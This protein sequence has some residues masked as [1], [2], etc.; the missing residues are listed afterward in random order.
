MNATTQTGMTDSLRY[1]RLWQ[2]LSMMTSSKLSLASMKT[3]TNFYRESWRKFH[4]IEHPCEML[5]VFAKV[6]TSHLSQ[7]FIR[8]IKLMIIYHDVIYRLRGIR[9]AEEKGF[10]ERMSAELMQT[11]LREAECEEELISLVSCGILATISHS[12]KDVPEEWH[13]VVGLFLDID[14]F[15]GLGET[16]ERF[17]ENTQKIAEEFSPLFLPE[18]FFPGRKKFAEGFADR[19][20]IFHTAHFASYEPIVKSN[21]RRY[22]AEH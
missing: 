13:E 11:Q 21:L 14:L 7:L 10:S 18:E 12:L 3:T 22:V 1:S 8:A 16:Y 17:L 5:D 9:Q 15:V 2:E 19:P 4:N 6:D 20:W